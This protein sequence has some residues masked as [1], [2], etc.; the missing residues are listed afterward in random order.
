[1]RAVATGEVLSF[2][3][4]FAA[5]R[6]PQTGRHAIVA[7][8]KVQQFSRPFHQNAFSREP[9]D[10]K[11]FMLVLRVDERIGKG[12]QTLTHGT[13]LNAA[14]LA[15]SDPEVCGYELSPVVNDLVRESK[16]PVELKRPRMH[17]D[18][19]RGRS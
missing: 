19:A 12:T 15:S 10:Y 11:F 8:F 2:T 4:F 5:V 6:L 17:Y 3:C 14:R 7:F 18:G 16:L 1:V 9:L 13:K